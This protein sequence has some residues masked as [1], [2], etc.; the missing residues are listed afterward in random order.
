V[1]CHLDIKDFQCVDCGKQF[2][3]RRCLKHHVDLFH[4]QTK[5]IP[6]MLCAAFVKKS[7]YESNMATHI[8][9]NSKGKVE[10]VKC[11]IIH[12][13]GFLLSMLQKNMKE[14]VN[15]N[16]KIVIKYLLK[17]ENWKCTNWIT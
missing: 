2:T 11:G 4:L 17:Q 3:L 14:R 9:S 7:S 13:I 8:K 12:Q 5:S 6:D 10:C 15:V 16:V 1:K